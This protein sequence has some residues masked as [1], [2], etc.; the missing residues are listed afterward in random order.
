M[1]YLIPTE[2]KLQGKA[3]FN[4]LFAMEKRYALKILW[5]Y[6]IKILLPY[7]FRDCW[8]YIKTREYYYLFVVDNG[9]EDRKVWVSILDV[10]L[11]SLTLSYIKEIKV[12]SGFL[13]ENHH[14]EHWVWLISYNMS[15]RLGSFYDW[16]LGNCTFI[17]TYLCSCFPIVKLIRT[18]IVWLLSLLD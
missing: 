2:K 13:K 4:K 12:T 8:L 15:T 18:L 7:F 5:R 9:I 10:W 6:A 16:R 17:L 14:I 1:S 3:K 11:V